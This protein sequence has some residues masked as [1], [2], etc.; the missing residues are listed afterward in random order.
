MDLE[1]RHLRCLVAIVDSGTF[2]ES[3]HAPQCTVSV[4]LPWGKG[5]YHPL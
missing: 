1:L 4:S 2:T 5:T 3:I